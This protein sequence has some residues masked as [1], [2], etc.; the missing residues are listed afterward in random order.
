MRNLKILGFDDSG[1]Y[2]DATPPDGD[3]FLSVSIDYVGAGHGLP[4]AVEALRPLLSALQSLSPD[5]SPQRFSVS[6][7]FY[8]Y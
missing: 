4:S 2:L 7:D 1:Q 5:S 3:A 8:N 6:F